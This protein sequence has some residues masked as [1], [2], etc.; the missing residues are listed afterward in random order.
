MRELLGSPGGLIAC[1]LAALWPHWLWL[2][3]RT[4]DGSDEPWGVLA[5]LTVAG[6]LWVDRQRLNRAPSPRWLALAAVLT[7]VAAVA[8]GGLPPILAAALALLAVAALLGGLLPPE[9]PRAALALLLLLIL[10]VG[11]SLNFYL[12]YPLRWLC[13]QGAAPLVALSGVA[14]T[15]EGAALTWN[16][17]QVLVDAPCAGIAMLWVGLFAALVAS[18]LRGA[19]PLRLLGNLALSA[20]IIVAANVLR[21]AVLFFKEAGLIAWPGWSHEAVGLAAF[22]LALYPIY[23]LSAGRAPW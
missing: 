21:N 10:P 17:R 2:V 13:A 1:Q 7:L 18:Y 16:G 3:R 20:L 8:T 6:L 4:G 14:V 11:A 5:L 19:P 12:G 9:R 23:R 22:A 15:P